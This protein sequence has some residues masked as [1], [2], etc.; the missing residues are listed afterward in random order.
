MEIPYSEAV[1][2]IKTEV[3]KEPEEAAGKDGEERKEKTEEQEKGEKKEVR[4]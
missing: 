1:R 4:D 3:K 2:E